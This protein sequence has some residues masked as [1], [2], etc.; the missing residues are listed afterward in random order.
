MLRDAGPKEKATLAAV[1]VGG[2]VF[3]G[4]ADSLMA[5]MVLYIAVSALAIAFAALYWTRSNW[6][7][8]APGRALMYQTLLLSA[9]GIWVTLS[10]WL[11]DRIPLK[12]EVRS[13]LLLGFVVVMVNLVMT[14][15]RVQKRSSDER[16]RLEFPDLFEE[17]S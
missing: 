17:R 16:R 3:I 11:K 12:D 7:R 8:T 15:L 4:V 1:T 9:L 10:I 13:V 14:L 2:A 6:R 5:G